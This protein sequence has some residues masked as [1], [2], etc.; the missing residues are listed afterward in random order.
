MTL[1][2]ISARTCWGVAFSLFIS[3]PAVSGQTLI[4]NH[5]PDL[6]RDQ[7]V[8]ALEESNSPY[9]L[10]A[11]FHLQ[12]GSHEGYL[13]LQFDLPNGSYVHSLTQSGDLQPSK[14]RVTPSNQFS[15]KGKFYPDR[16]PEVIEKDP[17]FQQRVE[18]HK[19]TVQFFVPIK[20]RADV[21]L[22]K[23]VPELVFN[24][25][26]CSSDGVC[27]P[28]RNKSVKAR[29]AGYFERTSEK[30]GNLQNQERK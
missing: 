12:Q 28:L 5:T 30:R 21:D 22:K 16:P 11:R 9:K 1:N 6:G 19:D 2:R 20:V 23:L 13:V 7:R 4:P 24:G 29:F 8:A 3:L 15:T 25:Q 17:V 14:I 10:S 26:V 18:K 27:I